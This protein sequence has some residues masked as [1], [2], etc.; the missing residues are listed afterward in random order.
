ME[1]KE[2]K[3]GIESWKFLIYPEAELHDISQLSNVSSNNDKR[4][5]VHGRFGLRTADT[6]KYNPVM[7]GP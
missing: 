7:F 5:I 2:P 4:T 6:Q 3:K 1:A